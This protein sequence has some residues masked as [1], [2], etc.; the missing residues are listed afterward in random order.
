[1]NALDY[2]EYLTR[3]APPKELRRAFFAGHITLAEY[4][5]RALALSVRGGR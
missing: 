1:M 2:L 3:H 4:R 5:A